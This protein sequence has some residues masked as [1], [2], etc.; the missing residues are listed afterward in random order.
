LAHHLESV[1]LTHPG[2]D[3]DLARQ[4]R[5]SDLIF[6][7]RLFVNAVAE[8]AEHAHRKQAAMGMVAAAERNTGTADAGMAEPTGA[9]SSR[10]ALGSRPY[11][12]SSPTTAASRQGRQVRRRHPSERGRCGIGASLDGAEALLHP[13]QASI[14]AS[15]QMHV[16]KRDADISDLLLD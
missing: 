9:S 14:R 8:R 7:L 6:D 3:V 13:G 2:I 12:A 5:A 4:H 16:S 15:R 11:C 10:C 1:G